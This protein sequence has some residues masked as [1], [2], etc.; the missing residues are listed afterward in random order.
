MQRDSLTSKE[1]LVI[2]RTVEDM[3]QVVAEEN[4]AQACAPMGWSGAV[5]PHGRWIDTFTPRLGV[6][7]P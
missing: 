3:L 7:L 1:W 6:W 2:S 4:R 5:H